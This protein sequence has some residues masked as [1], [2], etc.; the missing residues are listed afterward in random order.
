MFQAGS[1]EAPA[2]LSA[3]GIFCQQRNQ[4]AQTG[5]PENT[6]GLTIS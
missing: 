3:L 2:A 1:S 5:G 4:L 6:G